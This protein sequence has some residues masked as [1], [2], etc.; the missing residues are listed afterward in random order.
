MLDAIDRTECGRL[1]LENS[2]QYISKNIHIEYNLSTIHRLLKR[3]SFSWNSSR[4]VHP[5]GNQAHLGAFKNFELETTLHTPG[6]FLLSFRMK[7]YLGRKSSRPR[8]VK[9]QFEYADLFGIV[10]PTT[11][12]T[13]ALIIKAIDIIWK[14]F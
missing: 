7:H 11:C 9:Q 2:Q 14:V 4:T 8:I 5:K 12:E 3:Q 6:H 13:E 1:T 10:C